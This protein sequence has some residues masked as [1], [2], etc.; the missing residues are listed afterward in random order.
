M[1]ALRSGRWFRGSGDRVNRFEEAYA[2]LTGSKYC[3]ATANGTSALFAALGGLDVGPGD[4][5]I[6]P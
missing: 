3:V 4:E 2:R 6:L 5:V 1:D